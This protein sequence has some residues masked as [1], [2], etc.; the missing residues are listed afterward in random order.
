MFDFLSFQ[1]ILSKNCLFF[2]KMLARVVRN[3][4]PQ[5]HGRPSAIIKYSEHIFYFYELAHW[6]EKFIQHWLHF[7]YEYYPDFHKFYYPSLGMLFS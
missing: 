3:V 7:Y 5:N 6:R 2:N 1:N 4:V